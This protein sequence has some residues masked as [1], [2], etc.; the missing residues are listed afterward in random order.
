MLKHANLKPDIATD[1]RAS[2]PE[3]Q[4]KSCPQPAAQNTHGCASIA[5]CVS[6]SGVRQMAS[7]GL[8]QVL[9][10]A[11]AGGLDKQAG[12]IADLVGGLVGGQPA[13]PCGPSGGR[14][15]Q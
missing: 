12:G 14:R 5:G 8:F 7:I 3:I 13:F 10:I 4:A 15:L 2:T 9:D 6:N 11:D 1:P